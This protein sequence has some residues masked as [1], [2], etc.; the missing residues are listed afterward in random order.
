MA[1]PNLQ[2]HFGPLGFEMVGGRIEVNQAVSLNVDHSGPRSRG[3]IAL[4][5]DSPVLAPRLH[6]NYL[7]DP[8]DLREMVEG[9]AK[10]RELVAQPAFNEFRG[11]EMIPGA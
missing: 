2:Y 8:D 9:G 4:D 10:A 5:P 1:Y 7:Q 6:F 3:H 11:A